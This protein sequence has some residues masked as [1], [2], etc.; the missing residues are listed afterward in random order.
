MLKI[1][2]KCKNDDEQEKKESTRHRQ[3]RESKKDE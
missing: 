3:G 2:K 1:D